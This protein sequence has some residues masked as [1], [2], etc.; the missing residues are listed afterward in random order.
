M[1]QTQ[2]LFRSEEP[3][4]GYLLALPREY[5]GSTAPWPVV[6]FLHGRGECGDNL[7]LVKRYGLPKLIDESEDFPCV[8]VSPQCP[9]G[10]DWTPHID[11]LA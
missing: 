10:T 9:A 3:R 4:L 6:L 5:A 11:T 1:V 2:H 8:T 7:D